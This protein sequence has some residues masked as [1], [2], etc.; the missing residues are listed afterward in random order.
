MPVVVLAK[1]ITAQ[2]ALD[3]LLCSLRDI[4]SDVVAIRV[5]ISL[6]PCEDGF[7][8]ENRFFD[9]ERSD[10]EVRFLFLDCEGAGALGADD[11]LWSDGH[12]D[13]AVLE[14]VLIRM[15]PTDEEEQVRGAD[16]C[17]TVAM[18]TDD[19]T[20][21]GLDVGLNRLWSWVVDGSLEH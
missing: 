8:F 14:L 1:W 11:G 17:F 18:G 16:V 20:N 10:V 3:T 13:C 12:Q 2:T 21:G 5:F 19:L 7:G 15:R 9:F 4:T 6:F